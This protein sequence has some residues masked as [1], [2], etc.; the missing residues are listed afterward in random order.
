MF[1]INLNP[2]L[3]KG[4]FTPTVD[5][6]AAD[7]FAL[8]TAGTD[9]SAYAMVTVIWHLLNNPQMVQRLKAELRRVMPGREDTVDWAELEKLPY[10]VSKPFGDSFLC[11]SD[12]G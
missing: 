9:T 5:E 11:R 4:Q 6:M 1:D 10:L 2:N 12:Q 7:A 8:L 3:E